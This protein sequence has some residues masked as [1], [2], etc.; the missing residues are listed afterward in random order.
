M[1]VIR[2]IGTLMLLLLPVTVVAQE[3]TPTIEI[4]SKDDARAMFAMTKD[5]WIANLHQAV[6]A[7]AATPMGTPETGLG[8]AMNTP[9]G[10]L[11]VVRPIYSENEQTPDF[12]QVT[13]GYR[14]PRSTFLTD[15]ALEDAIQ[16]AKA[17]MMP[18]YDVTGSV[19]EMIG[20]ISVFFI[21]TKNTFR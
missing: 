5:E 15:A 21:I 19:E 20:G 12:I 18:D 7:G 2:R 3:A 14:Y 11:L 6:A 8:M 10:D 16:A 1:E 13:V 17:Q 4:L 9:D